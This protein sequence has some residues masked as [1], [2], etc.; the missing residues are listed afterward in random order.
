MISADQIIKLLK[1]HFDGDDE[2][3]RTVALQIAANEAKSGHTVIARSIKD[4]AKAKRMQVLKPRLTAMNHDIAEV[5][6]EV[7][8]SYKL[9]D[10]VVNETLKN[11]IKEIIKEYIQREKL[12]DYGLLNVHRILLEGPSGTGKTMTASVIANEIGLPLYVV[13]LEKIVTKYMG[14]TSLKLSRVFDFMT[15]ISGVYLFDE[16]DAI[17][18]RRGLDNEVGEMRRVLN[19]FLQMMERDTSDSIILTATN[20]MASLDQA[21]FRRFD[22]ALHYSLPSDED[23]MV[24]IQN[25]LASFALKEEFKSLMPSLRNMSQ[26]EICTI[27]NDAIKQTLLN[28]KEMN[29]GLLK[30]VAAMRMRMTECI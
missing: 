15:D 24:I 11:S 1:S 19:S 14:E 23:K 28:N 2:S 29:V 17:G 8:L 16:F 18:Q 3:F 10:L 9:A 21:L 6:L 5:L 30:E 12:K 22:K 13:R 25:K 20:D 7:D 26:S 27:C 4:L